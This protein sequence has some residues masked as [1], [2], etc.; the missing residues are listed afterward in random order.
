MLLTKKR[1]SEH[2]PGKMKESDMFSASGH[3][4]SH[5]MQ[6]MSQ[7]NNLDGFGM[8]P[9]EDIKKKLSFYDLKGGVRRPQ[10]GDTRLQNRGGYANG[11]SPNKS[12]ATSGV[13][14]YNKNSNT[15][16][17]GN[18][19]DFSGTRTSNIDSLRA[20]RQKMRDKITKES[21]GRKNNSFHSNW[22]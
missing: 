16:G 21:S 14:S 7:Q 13:Q 17:G 6:R 5:N 8:N 19:F 18:F 20:F 22:N 12:L 10:T 9:L 11:K 15:N 2:S 1:A 4:G 3:K